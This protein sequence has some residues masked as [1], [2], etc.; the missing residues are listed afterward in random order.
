MRSLQTTKRWRNW[1]GNL[2]PE[3]PM[4]PLA[5]WTISSNGDA[6]THCGLLRLQPAVA[7]SNSWP[8]AQPAMIWR[9][10]GSK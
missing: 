8:S 9:A 1:F 7:V 2:M 4:L 10:S 3:A 5:Y 6:A